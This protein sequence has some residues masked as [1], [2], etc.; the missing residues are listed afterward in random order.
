MRPDGGRGRGLMT[1]RRRVPLLIS[2]GLAVALV[3]TGCAGGG[4]EPKPGGPKPGGARADK[5]AECVPIVKEGGMKTDKCLPV[6][7]RHKRVDT[8]KPKFSHPL[9]ITNQ[10]HPTA[11]TT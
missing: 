7:S 10:L 6:A 1:C 3:G 5:P 4:D 11:R 8:Q 2:A 9:K